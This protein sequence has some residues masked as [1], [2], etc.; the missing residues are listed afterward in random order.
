M[1]ARQWFERANTLG[2]PLAPAGLALCII[3]GCSGPADP[4]AARPWIEQLRK[5]NAPRALFLEWLVA[6]RTAPI[7]AVSD[8]EPGGNARVLL[9]AR[10]LLVR[11]ANAGDP[12]A[13]IELGID[14]A[15]A[16]QW[17]SALDQFLKASPRSPAAAANA[18]TMREILARDHAAPAESL[19]RAR[20]LLLDARRVHRGEGVPANYG[21]ALRLYREAEQAGSEEA[22]RMLALIASRPTPG[23]GV[24]IEWMRQLSYIDLSQTIPTLGSPAQGQRL[25]REPSPLHDWLP[26]AWKD[27]L[28]GPGQ[29]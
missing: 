20:R 4:L 21:E 1:L 14:L 2:H 10:A 22:G 7:E 12:H 3:D 17:Q 15:G 13:Q 9:P 29:R 26:Q 11:A 18:S 6:Y 23:G 24:N 5:I 8:A 27:R 25:Q 19:A 28:A 16:R